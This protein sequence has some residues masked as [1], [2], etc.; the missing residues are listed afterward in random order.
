MSPIVFKA[1]EETS[2]RGLPYCPILQTVRYNRITHLLLFF[3]LLLLLLLL[4]CIHTLAKPIPCALTLHDGIIVR[5]LVSL[6]ESLWNFRKVNC[7]ACCVVI[8][9]E[10]PRFGL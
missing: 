4:V 3:L 7:F 8:Q 10:Q 9:F 6:K 2:S 1:D 5:S